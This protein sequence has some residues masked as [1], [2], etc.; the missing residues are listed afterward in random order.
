MS[1]T[2]PPSTGFLQEYRPPAGQH[3][4]FLTP[5]GQV[6]DHVRPFFDAINGLGREELTRRWEQAERLVDQ[7]GFAYGGHATPLDK[8]RPWELDAIPLVIS[9]AEWSSLSTALQQRAVLLNLVLRDLYGPRTLLHERVLPPDLVYSHPGFL[10]PFAGQK[11]PRDCFLHF[12][13][14]DLTRGAEGAWRVLADR[15]ESPSGMG[16]A[17]ENR[18]VVSR[19]LPDV[20]EQCRVERLA[21]FFIAAQE[22]LR[23]LAREHRQKPPRGVT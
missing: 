7:N 20:F 14:A 18:I 22:T 23:K 16:Y 11:P 9:P 13:A 12:Y 3:D 8:P 1:T 15:T 2:L 4:E 21:P 19:M 17:L 6:R 10:R 5:E